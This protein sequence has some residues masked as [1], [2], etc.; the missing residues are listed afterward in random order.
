MMT[1]GGGEWKGGHEPM[2]MG[3]SRSRGHCPFVDDPSPDCY[4]VKMDSRSIEESM[5]YCGGSYQECEIYRRR[6]AGIS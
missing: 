3:A 4:V 6:V 2:G 1:N 5:H